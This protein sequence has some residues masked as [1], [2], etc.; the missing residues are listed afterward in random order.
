MI[1]FGVE[2][3]VG[4]EFGAAGFG[5]AEFVAAE[6]GAAGFG[7]VN[8]GAAAGVSVLVVCG[9]G[10]VSAGGAGGAAFCAA[11]SDTARNRMTAGDKPIPKRFMTRPFDK[12]PHPWRRIPRSFPSF[13]E[14]VLVRAPRRLVPRRICARLR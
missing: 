7:G 2:S 13:R 12:F 1:G 4:S 3:A 11:L 8:V 14:R 6:F 10:V 5:A 9:A